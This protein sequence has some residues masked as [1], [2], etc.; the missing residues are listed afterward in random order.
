[1][2]SSRYSGEEGNDAANNAKLLR[3][4]SRIPAEDRNAR[5][6]CSLVFIDEDGSE[7]VAEGFI[8]GF[9]GFEERGDG[10]FGYD[11]LFC[12]GELK[13]QK[14]LPKFLKLKRFNLT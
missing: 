14:L 7:T 6:A 3:E 10:G 11:P 13:E 4:L 5:F 9:I 2:Y 12:S 1:M 8:E